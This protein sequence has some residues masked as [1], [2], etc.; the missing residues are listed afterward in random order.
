[1]AKPRFQLW[2]WEQINRNEGELYL[3]RLRVVSCPWFG[4]YVHWFHA[5]DDDSLHDHP[6]AFLTVIV[7]GGYWEHMLGSGDTQVK[8]WQPPLSVRVRPARWLHRI[9]ID[10]TRK[11]VTIVFRG[12][13]SRRWGFRTRGGWI[14]WADYKDRKTRH[15]QSAYD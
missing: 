15:S 1:M 10:P 6:W 12:P 2:R 8:L 3:E 4:L 11:P 13:Q 5:S 14:P 9:E 7:R